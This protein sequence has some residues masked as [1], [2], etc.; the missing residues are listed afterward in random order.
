MLTKE[1]SHTLSRLIDQKAGAKP[2]AV[3]FSGGGDST[4]LLSLVLAWA[5]KSGKPPVI[6]FIVDHGLRTGSDEEAQTAAWRAVAMG[7]QSKVL[8]WQGDKPKSG[9]QEK[10]RIARYALLGEACRRHGIQTLLLGHNEDD[11]AETLWMRAQKKSGWRGLAGMSESIE[12]PIWPQLYG[13]KVVRP[14]LNATRTE[15]RDYNREHN[16]AFIDD[17]SNENRAFTRIKAAMLCTAMKRLK[18]GF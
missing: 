6:A 7:A 13:V 14:L 2:L 3:A 5:R 4:A 8:R 11:Q 18:R 16:L 10:A 9:I 1:V 17:P 15:L 12:A